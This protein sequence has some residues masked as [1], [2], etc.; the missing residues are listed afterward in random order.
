VGLTVGVS[1]GK[2][3]G[4]HA[5]V[6]PN[7]SALSL[8]GPWQE[9]KEKQPFYKKGGKGDGKGDKGYA[10]IVLQEDDDEGELRSVTLSSGEVMQLSTFREGDLKFQPRLSQSE[11]KWLQDTYGPRWSEASPNQ[12]TKL[13]LQARQVLSNRLLPLMQKKLE[14]LKTKENVSAATAK[15]K[16]EHYENDGSTPKLNLEGEVMPFLKEEYGDNW[17]KWDDGSLFD[18]GRIDQMV[19]AASTRLREKKKA[20]L[21]E[22]LQ[23]LI[24]DLYLYEKHEA[25]LLFDSFHYS[26]DTLNKR[27]AHAL[28]RHWFNRKGVKNDMRTW[29]TIKELTPE[30]AKQMKKLR[31]A[32]ATSEVTK[33][34]YNTANPPRPPLTYGTDKDPYNLMYSAG[35]DVYYAN[36]YLRDDEDK[37]SAKGGEWVWRYMRA[38]EAANFEAMDPV[39]KNTLTSVDMSAEYWNESYRKNQKD[40]LTQAYQ[41]FITSV[42][43]LSGVENAKGV[44]YSYTVG[45]GKFNRYLRWP[46]TLVGG[47]PSK[48]PKQG[49][50]AADA[51]GNK[52][53]GDVGPP[54]L[55]HRLYKLVNRCPRLPPGP[56][57]VFLR[58]VRNESGLPHNLGKSP[59]FV[60]PEIGKRYL[61]VTFMSTSSAAPSNYMKGNLS[62]F[63]S[64]KDRCCMYAITAL[65]ETA[66]L[67]L[68][69]GGKNN[70]QYPDEQEVV[71]PPGLLLVFQGTKYL[72]VHNDGILT[73]VYFYQ[74][75]RPGD[76]TIPNA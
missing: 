60:E 45:S 42:D 59:P 67:P 17:N 43:L 37:I 23:Q 34:T 35:F 73:K 58:A 9:K 25:T 63:Y 71:L 5:G 62:A 75:A 31:V 66:V 44:A 20:Q 39:P 68:V 28:L 15:F 10:S 47:D 33:E 32:W 21:E 36:S 72:N 30:R 64:K 11:I 1:D 18:Q 46:S 52:F 40:R 69:L 14:E 76:V 7:L 2:M 3:D 12:L 13:K 56:P 38:L 53:Y 49:D 22:E 70:S 27:K 19:G 57:A 16:A 6:L 61:N 51:T 54:D 74:I 50:G 29:H 41:E 65:A 8:D 55:L 24:D 4:N 26:K 48:I